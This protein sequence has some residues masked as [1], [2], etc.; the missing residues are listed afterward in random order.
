MTFSRIILKGKQVCVPCALLY[1]VIKNNED[2][3]VI[4]MGLTKE[5]LVTYFLSKDQSEPVH[6]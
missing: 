3:I 5:E 4:E 6:N 2:A 1:D